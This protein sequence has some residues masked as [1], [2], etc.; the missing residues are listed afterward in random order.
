MPKRDHSLR[1]SSRRWK[2]GALKEQPV[3]LENQVTPPVALENQVTAPVAL[4][5]QVTPPVALENDI[6]QP[7]STRPGGHGPAW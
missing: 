2:R 4:E 1:W 5:N 6:T 7:W 3:A